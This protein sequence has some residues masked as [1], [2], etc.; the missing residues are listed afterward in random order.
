[1]A[2]GIKARVV[3]PDAARLTRA[4]NELGKQSRP[5]F[6][7]TGDRVAQIAAADLRAAAAGHSSQSRALASQV[8]SRRDRVPYVSVK[9]QGIYR[10]RGS[11]R[12]DAVRAGDVALGSEYGSRRHRVF[13]A[14]AHGGQVQ[15]WRP[16]GY[17]W[18]PTIEQQAPQWERVW[19]AALEDLLERTWG[20][21]A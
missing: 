2:A 13:V 5:V 1:M 15:V 19:L 21:L 7:E 11:R 12:R 18:N 6:R 20:R 16:S 4:M 8:S 14:P 9:P 10:L 3:S 17:W